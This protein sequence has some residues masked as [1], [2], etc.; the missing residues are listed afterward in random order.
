MQNGRQYQHML[1][2]NITN[3]KKSRMNLRS[4]QNLK[5]ICLIGKLSSDILSCC[6]VFPDSKGQMIG[7]VLWE[8]FNLSLYWFRYFSPCA[9]FY[10]IDRC[11]NFQNIHSVVTTDTNGHEVDV[12]TIYSIVT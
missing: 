11:C 10:L 5:T 9:V 2:T 1:W 3:K 7:G 4:Q 12:L 6:D 8:N